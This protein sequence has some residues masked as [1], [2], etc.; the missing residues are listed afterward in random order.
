[1]KTEDILKRLDVVSETS[2]G[3]Q[4]RC[5]AHDDDRPSLSIGEDG[6]KTL[7][8]CQA[9]CETEDIVKAMGLQLRDL[10][11]EE[12]EERKLVA[13]Y[14]Y[15]DENGE[16]LF[17]IL[18]YKPKNFSARRPDGNGGWVSSVKG[19]RLIPYRLPTI[20]QYKSVLVTEG[21]KDADAGFRKLHL[22]TTTNP[23]G[24]GKW[25]EEYSAH[26]VGKTVLL[27]PHKDDAGRNHM[28]AVACSL[29]PVAKKIKIVDLPFGKDLTEFCALGGTREMFLRLVKTAPAVTAGQIASW[30]QIDPPSPDELEDKS[31]GELMAQPEQTVEWLCDGLL[32]YGGSSLFSA[33][34]KVGNTIGRR[35]QQLLREVGSF[36]GA[37]R[38]R[39]RASFLRIQR[40]RRPCATS[41]SSGFPTMIPCESSPRASHPGISTPSWRSASNAIG[42]S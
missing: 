8:H 35:R 37:R 2:N 18:R 11:P 30:R 31:L 9:G 14:G 16:L 5:P 34:A 6:G 42:P 1:M 38:S 3:W 15:L 4:A 40:E 41:A 27:C 24:A 23:F 10:F 21:E 29:F 20:L 13:T 12:A 25:R 33:K 39:A 36:W 17:Q 32:R 19:T 28:R 7:L 22:P 26:F